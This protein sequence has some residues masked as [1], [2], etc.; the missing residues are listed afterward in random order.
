MK[1]SKKAQEWDLKR[2][3]VAVVVAAAVLLIIALTIGPKL[4]K[5]VAGLFG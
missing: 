5:M 1:L 3:I 4:M 2:I